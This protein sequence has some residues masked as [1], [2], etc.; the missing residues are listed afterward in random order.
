MRIKITSENPKETQKIASF[1]AEAL[2]K[3]Q[4][5]SA[6]KGALIVSLEG[7]L[8]SGKTEFLKGAAKAFKIKG[9]ITSPTF[10]IMKSFLCQK[11]GFEKLWHLDCYRIKKISE[12]KS[13]DFSDILENKNNIVFIEWGNK[14][15]K[16]LPADSL[17]IKFKIKGETQRLLEFDI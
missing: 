14:I 11:G 17:R 7:S 10:L 13:L 5:L 6:K 15:K 9:R 1:F 16:I 3:K 12:I 8:G 2:F 4:P